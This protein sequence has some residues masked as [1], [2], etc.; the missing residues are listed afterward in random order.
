MDAKPRSLKD[1]FD[2]QC[3]YLVPLY[4]R[5]YVWKRAEQWEPLWEDMVAVAERYVRRD[6]FRPHFM[7][8]VVLDQLNTATGTLDLRQII[9][10]QQRLTTLQIVIEAACDVCDALG[11]IASNHAYDLR[12]LTRNDRR[13][14]DPDEA[15]KVWPTNVDRE[16]FRRVMSAGAPS[17]LRQHYDDVDS[18]SVGFAIADGYFFFH[19]KIAEWLS[20]DDQEL[21]KSRLDALQNALYRGIMVVVIDLDEKDD[22]QMIFET[23]NARGTPLLASDLVKNYLLHKA[24]E[25]GHDL[26]QLY[27]EHWELF[28]KDPFWR[29]LIRTGRF[30]R[31]HIEFFLQNYLT[32]LTR[33]EVLVTNLFNVFR[34]HIKSHSSKD[35]ADYLAEL[36]RYGEIYHQF[37]NFPPGT[38][39]GQF[40]HRMAMLD[41]TTV[42]PLVLHVFDKLG[43]PKAA[44]QRRAILSDIESFLVRRMICGLTTKNYN[45]IFLDALK[46]V[47]DAEPDQF[48]SILQSHFLAQTSDVGRWPNDEEFQESWRSLEA[49]RRLKPQMRLRLVLEALELEKRRGNLTEEP[50]LPDT[51]LSI[52]HIMPRGWITNWPLPDDS[53][54]AKDARWSL[55]HTL[56]NLTLVTGSL[57]STL[58][59]DPWSK[60][61]KTLRKHSVLLLNADLQEADEWDETA[62]KKRNKDLFKLARKIWPMPGE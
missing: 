8:A 48:R 3:R 52:E 34:Q 19:E 45:N 15:F 41:T 11:S 6:P 33:D 9:D 40:F 28:D 21:L 60:K 57:N 35:P 10:G 24:E 37:F 30:S 13:S 22:A 29:W 53:Q 16:H 39:E 26:D 59:N 5:P 49:Y 55:I 42:F 4:Q 25:Y 17:E 32:L 31:P 43:T 20:V 61:R 7:G 62:I 47:A 50:S 1:I 18:E 12:K 38:P 23:L 27:A 58:S 51:K 46:L 56:G 2:A 44:K 36:K 14:N 54:E